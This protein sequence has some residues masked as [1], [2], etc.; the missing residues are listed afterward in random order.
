MKKSSDPLGAGCLLASLAIGI[1]V[2]LFLGFWA[3]VIWLLVW[4]LR[5]LAVIN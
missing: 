3:L 1:Q 5:Y 2:A 4:F